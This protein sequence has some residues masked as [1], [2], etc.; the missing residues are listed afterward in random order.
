MPVFVFEHASCIRKRANNRPFGSPKVNF[1]RM[2]TPV[3]DR[4]SFLH[5][6]FFRQAEQHP[7]SIAVI[8][9]TERLTYR[10]LAVRAESIAKALSEFGCG[11]GEIVAIDVARTADTVAGI[12]GILMV[13]AAYLPIEP[14]LPVSRTQFVLADC[15]VRFAVARTN[16]LVAAQVSRSVDASSLQVSSNS[17]SITNSQSAP[18]NL[19]YVMFTSGSTGSPKGVMITHS[20]A[21]NT[22]HDVNH[23]F[24]VGQHDRIL[25]VSSFAFDLSVYDLFGVLGAGGAV[26][27]P[28]DA[29]S[30]DPGAWTRL[31][32]EERVTIW[33]SVPA[34]MELWLSHLMAIDQSIG[35]D[36]R[37]ALLSGDWINVGLPGRLWSVSPRTEVVSLGGATEASIWS[38][39]HQIRSV[40]PAWASIPYGRPLTNQHFYILNDHGAHCESGQTGELYIGGAGVA[41]GYL[42]R[43]EL[44]VERF[45]PDR[46]SNDPRATMYRTGDYGRYRCDGTIEFLGRIDDQIKVNGYRIELAEIESRIAQCA[47]VSQCAVSAIGDSSETR[48][49]IAHIVPRNG[50]IDKSAVRA[51][52]KQ[53]LPP[54]MVPSSYVAVGSLPT[55][56]NG[57]VDR[58]MLKTVAR[59]EP[60]AAAG[61]EEQL[62][63]RIS[64]IWGDV[65]H[66][67]HVGRHDNF[68]E[69][70]GDSLAAVLLFIRLEQEFGNVPPLADLLE[71]PTVAE[72]ALLLAPRRASS[73]GLVVGL[74]TGGTR[75]PLYCLPGADGQLLVFR[76]LAKSIGRDQ[77]LY[78]LEPRGLDG[79][80]PDR[81]IEEM[82]ARGV[83]ELRH[84]QPS[85]PYGLAG[86]SAGGVVAFEMAR[87]LVKM[88]ERV[89]P[90]LLIDSF[91]GFP[92]G[93]SF[94]SRVIFQTRQLASLHWWEWPRR[95]GEEAKVA[96]VKLRGVLR[97]APTERHWTEGLNL[98]PDV[99][100]VAVATC[101]ALK[102]YVPQAFPGNAVLLRASIQPRVRGVGG[103]M[104]WRKLCQS[105][106]RVMRVRGTHTDCLGPR[107]ITSLARTVRM[108][109]EQEEP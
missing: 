3:G 7:E 55:N 20:A 19:A 95:I 94:F 51:H 88:G 13:G 30:H 68:F 100:R 72:L 80:E 17:T 44:S 78:G 22:I 60:A 98:T 26:V 86:F 87:R 106:L 31:V 35:E 81:T 74:Q 90:L 8:C 54:P 102:T 73:K 50:T 61:A 43:P 34:L 108:L 27:L 32:R 16:S 46:W 36:L 47:D 5:A 67:P 76:H 23:R 28:T 1:Q 97:N 62:T 70:G 103:D 41:V 10:T 45:V 57:K 99:A 104:G 93:P 53:H 37:L 58:A 75:R 91:P 40:D 79:S 52:L 69:L 14:R 59:S 96:S 9:G 71:H 109:L 6:G 24:S 66:L 49:L 48:R 85:G 12:L 29:E 82:A 18:R 56:A 65:L 11:L 83:R 77:P 2:S 64:R 63:A 101:Q 89:S 25:A 4:S 15:G 107:Y 38:I 105:G 42:N 33:N 21:A 39:F 84:V 92:L